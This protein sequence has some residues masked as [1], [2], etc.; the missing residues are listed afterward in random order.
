M[1]LYQVVRSLVLAALSELALPQV[2]W[3]R[4]QPQVWKV[5]LPQ[6]QPWLREQQPPHAVGLPSLEVPPPPTALEPLAS[7][8]SKVWAEV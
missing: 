3:Q 6:D 2:A 7:L 8:V 5:L 4:S 1:D